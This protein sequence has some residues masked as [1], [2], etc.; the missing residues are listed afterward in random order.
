MRRGRRAAMAAAALL[1]AALAV[2]PAQPRVRAAGDADAPAGLVVAEETLV[3]V[4]SGGDWQ[5]YDRAVFVNTGEETVT[6]VTL[7]VPAG[8]RDVRVAGDAASA[9][10]RDSLS[11]APGGAF[12]VATVDLAADASLPGGNRL[13]RVRVNL[14]PGEPAVVALT[15]TVPAASSLEW[16][17]PALQPVLSIAVLAQEGRVRLDAIGLFPEPPQRLE[18]TRVVVMT[19][20]DV[21]QGTLLTIRARRAPFWSAHPWT[22]ATVA[23]ALGLAALAATV[24]RSRRRRRQKVEAAANAEP[25]PSAELSQ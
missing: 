5:V 25:Q 10:P 8:A 22:A 21:A 6:D 1:A 12:P 7:P 23:A 3:L 14:P 4:P 20:R 11:A 15:W 17:R 24:I 18:D 2:L 13:A 16:L 19:A 9:G